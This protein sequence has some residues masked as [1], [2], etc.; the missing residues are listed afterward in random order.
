MSPGTALLFPKC[1][2]KGPYR[3]GHLEREVRLVFPAAELPHPR[4]K[5]PAL[6]GKHFP[7][8]LLPVSV[9]VNEIFQIRPLRLFP[10]FLLLHRIAEDEH[11]RRED[12]FRERKGK[13]R[14]KEEVYP[15][16]LLNSAQILKLIFRMVR[17][18]NQSLGKI[19]CETA[20]VAASIAKSLPAGKKITP[21]DAVLLSLF[22]LFGFL[23]FFGEKP[24]RLSELTQEEI[25][26]SFLY[27]YYY[28]KEMSP[29]GENAK[30]LLFYDKKY[31][32]YI[33]SKQVLHY[34]KGIL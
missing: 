2:K 16:F 19:S 27:G 31:D 30:T 7:R 25:Y 20:F 11:G 6:I 8:I 22:H 5:V 24:V 23:H 3:A 26:H 9:F 21:K 1:I 12:V 28:L 14:M 13:E 15:K 17:Q 4:V 18:I 10:V 32:H 34:K 29:L 33:H